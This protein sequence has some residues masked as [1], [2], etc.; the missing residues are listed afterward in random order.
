MSTFNFIFD[1]SGTLCDDLEL[2]WKITNQTLEHFSQTS[3][4]LQEYQQEFTIPLTGFYRK[5]CPSISQKA[6]DTYFFEAYQE[7]VCETKLYPNALK[8]IQALSSKASLFILSTL[9]QDILEK[10]LRHLKIDHLF[11]QVYGG[12][13]DKILFLPKI[14]KNHNL[15]SFETFFIGD[16]PHDILTGQQNKVQSVGSTYGYN[17]K[18][19]I[20]HSK[21]DY[22][23]SD[24]S[25]MH[26]AFSQK[27]ALEQLKIPIVSIGGL[28]FNKQKQI[29]LIFTKKWK[30][31]WGTPGGKVDYGESLEQ[32][33]IREVKEE[34]SLTIHQTQQILMQES[35]ECLEFHKKKHFILFHFIG[36]CSSN[37]SVHLNYESSNYQWISLEKAL[38]EKINKPTRDL[39]KLVL[40]K[41][42]I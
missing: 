38:L 11:S 15:T 8:M 4:S 16:T 28:V 14:I 33:F 30:N 27:I 26:Q 23:F 34:T 41:K 19:V 24:I 5:Y 21:P 2:S 31:L 17:S 7:L 12:A 29:L 42:Y 20:I 39:I 36:F 22:H 35:I 10:I 18:E 6:I 3:I 40:K 13:Y 37:E 1:W 25:S 9:S 32:A